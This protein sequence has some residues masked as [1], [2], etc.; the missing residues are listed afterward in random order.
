[1]GKP[2]V[3]YSYHCRSFRAGFWLCVFFCVITCTSH[4]GQYD[5][6]VVG[7][8]IKVRDGDTLC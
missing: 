6:Y 8:V 3:C 2:S 5:R 1:M 7:T 4:A